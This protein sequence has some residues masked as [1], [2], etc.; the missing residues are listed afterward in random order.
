MVASDLVQDAASVGEKLNI[1]PHLGCNFW[2]CLKDEEVDTKL[3]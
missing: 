2:V 3:F 1:C